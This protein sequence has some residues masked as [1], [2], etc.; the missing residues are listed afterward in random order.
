MNFYYVRPTKTSPAATKQLTPVATTKHSTPSV[1]LKS[2]PKT[3]LSKTPTK[4]QPIKSTEKI[5]NG[6]T[7][8]SARPP[9]TRKPAV[10]PM[11][12][13]NSK[14]TTSTS[15][16]PSRVCT[17]NNCFYADSH[18]YNFKMKHFLYCIIKFNN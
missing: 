15:A 13:M 5:T 3:S 14:S 1:A 8:T 17:F 10:D 16:P 18:L 2:T 9:I 4:P 12:K 6:E 11:S 7:K